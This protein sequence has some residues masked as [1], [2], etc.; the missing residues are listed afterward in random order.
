MRSTSFCT[1][2]AGSPLVISTTEE[3]S[4]GLPGTSHAIRNQGIGTYADGAGS[5]LHFLSHLLGGG[6][7]DETGRDA[8]A[9]EDLLDEEFVLSL[10]RRGPDDDALVGGADFLPVG[11]LAGKIAFSCFLVS[12]LI[13]MSLRKMTV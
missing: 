10:R 5:L 3:A 7:R 2:G 4:F 11:D 13:L 1:F 6:D 12:F 9:L 8:L